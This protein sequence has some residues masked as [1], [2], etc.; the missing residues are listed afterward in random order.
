[1]RTLRRRKQNIITVLK[2]DLGEWI[3]DEDLLE[4]ETVNF[5]MILYNEHLNPMREL[6]LNDFTRLND[7][8]T[9]LLNKPISDEEIKVALSDMAPLKA[10]RSD[11]F[12]ALFY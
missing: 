12:H 6:P 8:D 2:N 1:M 4:L 7:E 5:Y 9:T 11:G 3:L 10:Q